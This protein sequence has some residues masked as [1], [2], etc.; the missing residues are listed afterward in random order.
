LDEFEEIFGEKA[1]TARQKSLFQYPSEPPVA[2][3]V[4]IPEGPEP[5]PEFVDDMP[6]LPG[7]EEE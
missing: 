6:E 1:G 7:L 5:E 4:E 3:S 2:E